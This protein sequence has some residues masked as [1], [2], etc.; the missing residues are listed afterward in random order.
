MTAK[1]KISVAEDFSP[2]P[3]GRFRDD[4]PFPGEVFRDE[5]L[6]PALN[7]ND[8]VIVNLDGTAGY[9]S[10]F[11]EE[12]FGG[13]IRCGFTKGDLEKRLKIESSRESYKIR[14]WSYIA[15]EAQLKH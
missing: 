11:L 12:A 8:E 3:A 10:S 15:E 14:A 13:L 2:F 5:K 9:G 1:A 4:G 7:G 6:I